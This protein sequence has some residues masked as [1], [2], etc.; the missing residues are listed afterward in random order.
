MEAGSPQQAL[1][2]AGLDDL[3]I[4]KDVVPNYSS[5]GGHSR[6]DAQDAIRP[7]KTETDLAQMKLNVRNSLLRPAYDVKNLYHDEGVFQKIARSHR[8]ENITLGVISFNALWIWIDT[9]WNTAEVLI[10]AE[11]AFQIVEH[12]FCVFFTFEWAVRFASFKRK[13]DGLKD[14]WFVFDSAL[15]LMMVLETWVMSAMLLLGGESGSGAF[16]NASILRM[17]RLMRLS[18]MARMVRLFRAMPELLILIR[19]M[20]AATRSVFFTLCLL[21]ILLYVFGIAF[22]QLA[23][24]TK[25]G[26]D[27]FSTVLASMYTLLIDA[28]FMDNLGQLVREVG[29]EIP[30]CAALMWVFVLL[31]SL[32]VMNM[33]IGVLCEVVS[34]VAAT[35]KET[36]TVQF[37]KERMDLFFRKL[38]KDTKGEISKQELLS[39]LVVPEICRL[40]DDV[41]VDSVGLIDQ[42]DGIFVEADTIKFEDMVEVI[43]ELRGSNTAKVKNIVDLRNKMTTSFEH[44]SD[45]L[46]ALSQQLALIQIATDAY[47]P[48]DFASSVCSP[49]GAR[50]A[51]PGGRSSGRPLFDHRA[52]GIGFVMPPVAAYDSPR[53]PPTV[54]TAGRAPAA[55]SAAPPPPDGAVVPCRGRGRPDLCA[56]AGGA[57]MLSGID[58]GV[59]APPAPKAASSCWA[60]AAARKT[61]EELNRDIAGTLSSLERIAE[62]ARSEIH[63]DMFGGLL[64]RWSSSSPRHE[65]SAALSTCVPLL[66]GEVEPHEQPPST[67][68][69]Q[70]WAPSR[71]LLGRPST[72]KGCGEPGRAGGKPPPLPDEVPRTALEPSFCWR[73]PPEPDQLEDVIVQL[74]SLL[75]AIARVSEL[76]NIRDSAVAATKRRPADALAA[77]APD[78]HAAWA[79]LGS[80]RRGPA[81]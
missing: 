52:S 76:R 13:R 6:S 81:G 66:P 49:R 35:E 61:V 36:L 37:V 31:S 9:D 58:I 45:K 38:D 3:F 42:A 32:T 39:A 56:I 46:A 54:L 4:G 11:P 16:G 75:E 15:V 65:D 40:L 19:G 70:G 77:T 24:N 69:A 68:L 67:S 51:T 25:V 33:L 22:R 74:A 80:A 72:L 10:Q 62:E 17:A 50:S 48:A 23:E 1:Q 41:G 79:P 64:E 53:P 60:G 43:L 18:R 28:T 59:P 20:V 30:V 27:Y 47:T 57:A 34:A 78:D 14:R 29:N 12:F 2:R 63:R 21:L 71:I 7:N 73:A 44:V 8:F 26:E 55:N 5:H